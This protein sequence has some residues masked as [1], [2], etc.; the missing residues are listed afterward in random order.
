MTVNPVS[1]GRSLFSDV[2]KVTELATYRDQHADAD[3]TIEVDGGVNDQTI[4]ACPKQAQMPL[5]VHTFA[6]DCT[7]S[8]L[9]QAAH[10]AD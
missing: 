2:D 3:Y 6:G 7:R 10:D 5:P 1:V 8:Q 4:G 9:K